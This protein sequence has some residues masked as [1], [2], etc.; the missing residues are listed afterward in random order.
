MNPAPLLD[1]LSPDW[2]LLRPPFLNELR[3]YSREKLR[4]DLTAAATVAM[5]SIP[6]AVGFALIAGLPPAMV[7]ACVVVGGAVAA[8][9]FSS[10]H[11]IF[12]PSNSL[13]LL[14]ATTFVAHRASVLG[15]AE[16][17]ILLALLI[18]T[19]QLVAGF[20]R[21]GQVTQFV[22]RS[23]V[24]GYGSAIGC[25]LVLSQL[26]HL[27]GVRWTEGSSLWAAPF[28]AIQRVW[29]G[30]LNFWTT[31]VAVAAFLLFSLIK[32]LRPRWPEALIGLIF[33]A[34]LARWTGLEELGIATLGQD[35]PLFARLPS[36]SGI[37]TIQGIET[38]RSLLVPAAALAL[39]GTL[40]AISIAKTYSIKTGDHIDTNQEM[41]AMGLGNLASACFAAIPGS[42]SFAR[43]AANVQAGARTQA[44]GLFSSLFVLIFV[45]LLAPLIDHIPVAV[46]AAALIRVGWNIVDFDQIRI[47][48]RSTRSDAVVLGGT[49]AAA[50]LLPLDVAIY[51]GVGLSLIL[52]LRKVSV[53]TLVEYAFNAGDQLTQLD[54]PQ[55]RSH[56]HIAIIH[57][58]GEL[59]FGAADLFQDHVRRQVEKENLRAVILRLKSA[60]HLDAT[61]I[62]AL[63]GLHDYLQSTGRHLLVSGVHGEVLRVLRNSGLLTRIGPSNVFPAE[64][65]PNLAT[66]KALRR[67]QQLLGD[68]KADIRIYFDR[69]PLLSVAP[70]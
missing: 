11:V 19:M 37:P 53:P 7:L 57:V 21:F 56:P 67:A 18:G 45:A 6:Q 9:F 41:V 42:A 66:K 35:G 15:P 54:H 46:L 29:V 8:L 28:H 70:V 23:V 26:H 44:A 4:A 3:D 34:L 48:A 14:L 51:T 30:E 68:A 10:R 63:R 13:S 59:F 49:F 17:A 50:L 2:R 25:L 36:F 32:R 16:I 5:V 60:R 65:N 31:G 52:A 43:S 27:L 64:P 40:E 69:A 58:E 33:F 47:A 55:Q 24:I 22:S 38:V 1:S 20:L 39:L 12:G 62:F 61:T